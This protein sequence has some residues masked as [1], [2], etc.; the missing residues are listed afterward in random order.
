MQKFFKLFFLFFMGSLFAQENSQI[1]LFDIEPIYEGLQLSNMQ[2]ISE[3]EGYNNQPSFQSNKFILFAGNNEGQSD[4]AQYNI[5]SRTR[6]WYNVPTVEGGEYS[7]QKFPTSND[8]AA[9]RLDKDGL[10]RLYKYSFETRKPSVLFKDTQVAYFAFY[11]D[12]QL[13]GTV[14]SGDQMDLVTMNIS[15]K[16]V[17]TLLRNVGRSIHKVPKSDYMSYTVFNEQKNLDVYLLDMKTKES[18]FVCEMPIGLQDY[19][20]F[21]ENQILAGSG[22]KLW[23]YD[24]LGPPE[25]N[26]VANL[27]EFYIKNPT[28]MAISPDGKHIA[29]VATP[30][31]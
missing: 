28:R 23:M 16:K 17:D 18:F 31:K 7:P 4:I 15:E 14:L 13:L 12:N 21:N 24:T 1:F 2:T 9:V 27:T 19:V 29:I 20:W 25:W 11:N 26:E 8:V 5:E 3:K 30:S 22:T 6:L 10:Q